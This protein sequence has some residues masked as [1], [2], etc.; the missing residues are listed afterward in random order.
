MGKEDVTV[1]V[2]MTD[3]EMRSV[4]EAMRERVRKFRSDVPDCIHG[5]AVD[6]C[7][8]APRGRNCAQAL[9]PGDL[10]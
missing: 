2:R 4:I 10:R 3:D 7:P 5:N 1:T 8:E 6:L 9:E